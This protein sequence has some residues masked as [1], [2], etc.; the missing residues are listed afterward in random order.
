MKIHKTIEVRVYSILILAF[1]AILSTEARTVIHN[2]LPGGLCRVLSPAQADTCTVLVVT[3]NLN[4][5]DIHLLRRMAGYAE[6]EGERTGRLTYLDLSGARLVSDKE[7]YLTVDAEQARLCLFQ[8]LEFT[9]DLT[10]HVRKEGPPGFAA[11]SGYGGGDSWSY[12]KNYAMLNFSGDEAYLSLHSYRITGETKANLIFKSMRRIKGHRLR[13]ADG[14]WL[15]SS[16]IRKGRFCPDMFFGCSSL[17][18]VIIPE[19]IKCCS[20][21]R[22]CDDTIKYYVRLSDK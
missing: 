20:R 2:P 21:V 18:T 1:C 8:R 4:S 15:W 13:K 22:V 16:H 19:S 10:D 3:G 17:K 9:S 12:W 14:R 7:P 6:Y 11:V 5:A